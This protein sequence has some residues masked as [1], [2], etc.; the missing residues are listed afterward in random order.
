MSSKLLRTDNELYI[1]GVNFLEK[2]ALIL[3]C[4][5]EEYVPYYLP[6]AELTLNIINPSLIPNIY[7]GAEVLIKFKVEN[8]ESKLLK[9]RIM[10]A[11]V[12]TSINSII[13]KISCYF[14]VSKIN[15]STFY[16]NEVTSSQIAEYIASTGN[17]ESDISKTNDKQ[18]WICYGKTLF[19]F[20]LD[21]SYNSWTNETSCIV[22]CFSNNKLKF[23]NISDQIQKKA[24]VRF[25][26][27]YEN[28]KEK[29]QTVYDSLVI[30]FD[31]GVVNQIAGYGISGNNFNVSSGKVDDITCNFKFKSVT[32]KTNLNSDLV[33]VQRS[34]SMPVNC[35][36]THSNYYKAEL[37]NLRIKSL[38]SV[39]I[40]I[41]TEFLVDLE[42]LD[43]VE[44]NVTNVNNDINR[45][46][47]G[48]YL[49]ERIRRIRDGNNSMY[50]VYDLCR[51]GV[52]IESDTDPKTIKLK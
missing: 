38:Y 33:K 47:S 31:S 25:I 45:Q 2:G 36:N 11:K 19:D 7:D 1:N 35:G 24:K 41:S 27:N 48:K 17:M 18:S 49:V 6:L 5:V 34:E 44:V 42:L 28:L 3:E 9:F 13:V 52:N 12:N 46:Y 21:T 37:Q 4:K 32:D 20:L 15:F 50:F 16:S 8:S 43:P 23:L 30:K 10:T 29:D 26:D 39:K 40:E 14:D 22:T 51:P